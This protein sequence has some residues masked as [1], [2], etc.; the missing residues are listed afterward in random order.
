MLEENQTTNKSTRDGFGDAIEEL[1]EKNEAVVALCGDL[2][3]STKLTKFEQSFPTRF[4]ECGVAEQNMVGV[5]TGLALSGKI[6]FVAS[7]AA[8]NPGRNWDQIRMAVCI[9][10]ANVKIVGSH[11]GFSNGPDG[12]PDE[13]LEDIAIMR[14]LPNMVVINPIDYDQ[15]KKAVTAAA[16][17]MGPVYLRLSKEPTPALTTA[18]TPFEIG[19]GVVLA[20]L[21][22]NEKVD[23][24]F[25]STG[26]ITK[27]VLEAANNLKIKY[28]VSSKVIA[29]PTIKPLD[30]EL[31]LDHAK[32]TKLVVTVEEHQVAGGLGGAVAETLSEKLPTK[33]LR[34]GMTDKFGMSGEYK[35]LLDRFGLSAHHI[36]SRV[37]KELNERNHA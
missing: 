37:S 29:M 24:L 20:N 18:E 8:F 17:H 12:A 6:P 28:K 15:T 36:V 3:D 2:T 34:I 19:K 30:A 23:V 25:I 11:S 13:P 33:L 9:S 16:N 26:P 1:A 10:N 4:I 5:A 27:E 32:N 31:I 14:V 7:H 21:A 35:E 22:D